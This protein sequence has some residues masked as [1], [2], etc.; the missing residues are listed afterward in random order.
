MRTWWGVPLVA[1]GEPRVCFQWPA[2]RSQ[3][4]PASPVSSA[5]PAPPSSCGC[6]A[7]LDRP[8]NNTASAGRWASTRPVNV[9]SLHYSSLSVNNRSTSPE[10]NNVVPSSMNSHSY[11]RFISASPFA[12]RSDSRN[13]AGTRPH[14]DVFRMLFNHSASSPFVHIL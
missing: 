13:F 12:F 3:L 9:S 2:A 1:Y 6:T 4:L 5:S 7:A 14:S 10:R 11:S 8:R